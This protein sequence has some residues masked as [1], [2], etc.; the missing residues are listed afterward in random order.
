MD[1]SRRILPG[2]GVQVVSPLKGEGV[3]VEVAPPIASPRSR[4][5][6]LLPSQG[7]GVQVASRLTGGRPQV[8]K[9]FLQEAG[10]RVP[11]GASEFFPAS[12]QGRCARGS[13][14][15]RTGGFAQG[16]DWCDGT[17]VRGKCVSGFSQGQVRASRTQEAGRSH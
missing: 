4:C 7:A 14:S 13:R 9:W 6:C 10:V 2:A 8:C 12:A 17:G 15:R 1:R 16:Q 5:E 11:R 3:S